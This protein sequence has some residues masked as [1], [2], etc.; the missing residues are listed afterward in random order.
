M[1]SHI[2]LKYQFVKQ[3]ICD[4][5]FLD[6]LK[7]QDNL[8]FED[9]DESTFLKEISW[10]ILSAGMKE[11]V[12]RKIYQRLTPHF[13]YW[14]SSRDIVNNKDKCYNNAIIIFNNSR[15]IKA[16]IQT[17]NIIY[18]N[19]FE[20][21]K[22][23]ISENPIETLISF[24]FIGKITVYHIAKNIGLSLAKPD[25]HLVRIAKKEGYD[26]VQDFCKYISEK[27]GD[28]ISVVD[29]VFWRFANLNRD[30]LEILSSINFN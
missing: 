8:C 24:P 30:Y 7:W 12:I 1:G 17:A 9:L 26:D 21:I 18:N 29:I 2:I 14:N 22:L 3:L 23:K 27:S 15:K 13:F 4:E 25:R 5:G 28:S 11:Q 16:I 20:N 19:G 6:E 10:V